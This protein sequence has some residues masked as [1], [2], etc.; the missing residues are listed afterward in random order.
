MGFSWGGSDK[1]TK[2]AQASEA[3]REAAQKQ[4]IAA[5]NAA[6]D[7]PQRAAQIQ[8]FVDATQTY[9]GDD[10]SRQ[11]AIND[12]QLKFSLARNG[13]IGGSTQ[14]DQSAKLGQD[15][16]RGV[17]Q[18]TQQ[19]QGA[20]ANLRQQD[21]QSKMNLIALSNQGLDA[22]TAATEAAQAQ[23]SALDSAKSQA[24]VAGL[25][26]QFN[27]LSDFY[28]QSQSNAAQQQSFN[29]FTGAQG[30]FTSNFQGSSG[31]QGVGMLGGQQFG[32][33]ASSGFGA[34]SAW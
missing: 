13:Q 12:R 31:F 19:A 10:L 2:A 28:Q 32:A 7:S 5:I 14:I 20:G 27:D 8:D 15:Y 6:Y 18:V 16:A 1:A 29:Q 26:G 34:A 9:L 33:G 17:L 3:A 22:T 11:K 30:D 25:T 23:G 4:T 21:E 24:T